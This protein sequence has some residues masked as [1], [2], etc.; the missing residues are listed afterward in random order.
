M[1][2]LHLVPS[3][4]LAHGLDTAKRLALGVES[5]N[6]EYPDADF[7]VLAGDLVDR[8][9]KEAYQRLKAIMQPLKIPYYLALGN[10]DDR[11]AFLSVFGRAHCDSN[12]HVQRVIDHKGYRV[13]VLDSLEAGRH[14][15][16]LCD[17]RLAWLRDQLKAGL[18]RPVIVII[19]HHVN[20][21]RFFMDDYLLENPNELLD[22]LRIHP[23]VRHVISGHVHI[24]TTGIIQGIPFT[25]VAGGHYTF[26]VS[27]GSDSRKKVKKLEG[28]AQYAVVLADEA[29]VT[30]HFHN[31]I[32]QHTALYENTTKSVTPC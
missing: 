13:I 20:K 4:E 29:S 8:G 1:S 32:D 21:V 22:V 5:I 3:P 24:S 10:H 23:D 28:P 25:T 17:K 26:A 18:D 31:Y 27:L 15:G 2:D 7:C 30:V 11:E 6:Q 16:V 12:G 9:D 19:H 14:T